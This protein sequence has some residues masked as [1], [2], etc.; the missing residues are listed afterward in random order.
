ML[1]GIGIESTND[2]IN[3]SFDKEAIDEQVLLSW[4]QFLE[5]ELLSKDVD[6]SKELLNLSKE[7]KSEMWNKEKARLGIL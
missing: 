2:K 5:L 1:Q 3:V 6:F 4:L 7:I